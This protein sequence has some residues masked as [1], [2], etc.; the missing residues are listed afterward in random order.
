MQ[1]PFKT[2]PRRRARGLLLGMVALAL[3]LD[4]VTKELVRTNLERGDFWPSQDWPVRVHHVT[5]TGAA[6]G[7]LKDQTGFLIITA[8]LGVAAIL[9][10]YR[11]PPIQHL[12]VPIAVGM[13]L[14][15]A[16][17]NLA[18]RIRLGHVTDFI[19]FP[20]WPAFNVADASIVVAVA[21]LIAAY[22]LRLA[23]GQGTQAPD[24]P[25]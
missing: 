4:Q 17:G 9:L 22:T 16:V 24:V 1:A 13:M 25:P 11:N 2:R 12:S 6:F 3:A 5:N 8:L 10:Y 14:G 21:V 15:G 7:I 19:D 18:D 20:M 23:G